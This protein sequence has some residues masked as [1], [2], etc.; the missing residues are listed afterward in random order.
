[1]GE[2]SH[3]TL[4]ETSPVDNIIIATIIID[5]ERIYVVNNRGGVIEEILAPNVRPFEAAV[6][7]IIYVWL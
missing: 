6:K 4:R 5:E 1:L 2:E 7:L 3:T